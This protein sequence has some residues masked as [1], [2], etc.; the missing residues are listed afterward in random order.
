MN[1]PR[2]PPS[3]DVLYALKLLD[4]GLATKGV[5]ARGLLGNGASRAI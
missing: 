4:E 1:D 3:I 2:A 5:T